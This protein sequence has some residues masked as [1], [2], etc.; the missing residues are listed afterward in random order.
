MV[1]HE[2]PLQKLALYGIK[3]V[4]LNCNESYISDRSQCI[5]DGLIASSRQSI[6]SGVPQSSVL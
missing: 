2:I 5:V 6:K 3:G 4:S 1:Y